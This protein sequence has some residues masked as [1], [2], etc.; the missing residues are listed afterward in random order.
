MST[1]RKHHQV[2]QFLLRGFGFDGGKR[3]HAFDKRAG[4]QFQVAV[5]DAAAQNG[6][7]NFEVDGEVISA[8]LQLSQ[9]E[10]A[11]AAVI[12]KV[13]A[14]ESVLSLSAGEREWLALFVSMQWSRSPNFRLMQRDLVGGFERQ[15]RDSRSG[16]AS[17]LHHE[18][19][20]TSCMDALA[21]GCL[22]RARE[23][24]P[25]VLEKTWVLQKVRGEDEL[26]VSDSP[27]TLNNHRGSGPYGN[28][29]F[30]IPWVEIQLPISS[31]LSLWMICPRLY[32]EFERGHDLGQQMR[33]AGTGGVEA[34]RVIQLV[35][36]IRGGLPLDLSDDNVK[37]LNHLQVVFS[38]R[39][40]YSSA[41]D[42]ALVR[43][44]LADD[45]KFR[46]GL[47]FES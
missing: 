11:A 22:A 17:E 36:R 16:C 4:T 42:F 21:L 15:V 20:V 2:P 41:G 3:L 6:Y 33:A 40:I 28:L 43:R 46:G 1:P 24:V 47:R 30:G 34:A 44:M 31:K 7:Y 10:S 25:S 35:E 12:A 27:L 29:G 14:S 23:L 8:E 9:L 38:S 13:I 45:A 18:S 19:E 5:S 37:F 32:A 39:F 26:F